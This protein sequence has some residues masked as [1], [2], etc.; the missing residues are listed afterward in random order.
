MLFPS[1]NNS[2]MGDVAN[3]ARLNPKYSDDSSDDDEENDSDGVEWEEGE[4][5]VV[6]TTNSNG[7]ATPASLQPVTIDLDTKPSSIKKA[8]NPRKRKR[9]RVYPFRSL[10]NNLKTLLLNIHRTHMLTL[11]S[12]AMMLSRCCSDMALIHTAHSLIPPPQLQQQWTEDTVPNENQVRNLC[13]WYF[14]H[15]NNVAERRQRMEAWNVRA[16]APR[17]REANQGRK[18][19][20]GLG[21]FGK[22]SPNVAAVSIF[23]ATNLFPVVTVFTVLTE[24][25]LCLTY[26]QTQGEGGTTPEHLLQ[27]CSY[28]STTH[29]ENPQLQ[30]S[31]SIVLTQSDKAQILVAIAR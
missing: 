1:N 12:R 22:V 29:D 8:Q 15:V 30:E 3:V 19:T 13:T 25:S 18:R 2:P 27:I 24:D 10:P 16:G 17:Q 11:A 14:D 4:D 6:M 26:A 28:L 31:D 21:N 7:N 23:K 20:R 5:D 9:K